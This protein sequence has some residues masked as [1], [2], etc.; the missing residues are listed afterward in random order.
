MSSL[1][2]Y[3][4]QA[5]SVLEKK[6]HKEINEL[7]GSITT[8]NFNKK[9]P[10][11]VK[12]LNLP[13]ELQYVL[14][15]LSPAQKN[16]VLR[17]FG[18]LIRSTDPKRVNEKKSELELEDEKIYMKFTPKNKTL[19]EYLKEPVNFHKEKLGELSAISAK[20]PI[21][22]GLIE[23]IN[24]ESTQENANQAPIINKKL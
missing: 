10:G 12:A 8:H 9:I 17:V 11:L 20:N 24:K 7:V 2:D 13:P 3:I 4:A 1:T 6:N 14:Q 5:V 18:H 22:E 19:T 15:E 21:K 16:V 23:I